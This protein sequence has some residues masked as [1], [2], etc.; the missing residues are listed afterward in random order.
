MLAVRISKDVEDR[1]KN[2][3]KSTGRTKSFYVKQAIFQYLDSQEKNI[4]KNAA[5]ESKIISKKKKP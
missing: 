5:I 3:A 2:L 1:L 4:L